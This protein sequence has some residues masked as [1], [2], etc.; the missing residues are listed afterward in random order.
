MTTDTQRGLYDALSPTAVPAERAL[1]VVIA[2]AGLGLRRLEADE[3]SL[4]EVFVELVG[5][6]QKGELSWL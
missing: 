6:V 2:A 5:G 4:E 1:P 3:V